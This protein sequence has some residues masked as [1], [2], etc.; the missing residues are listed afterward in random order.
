MLSADARL[1]TGDTLGR[2]RIL[3]RLRAGGMATLYLGKRTGAAGFARP[4][5]IKVIHPHL[6]EDPRFVKM[7]VDEATLSAKIDDP[8]VVHVEELGEAH[9]TY[10]LVMEYVDGI[11]LAQLLRELGRR[12]RALSIDLTTWIA[13]QIAAGLHAA[14]EATNEAGEPLG[15]VHRD[16]SP[17][18]VLLAFKGHVKLIDFG[19]AKSRTQTKDT[20]TGS[21]R[22]K[23]AYMPPEQAWGKSVDRRA[24]VY[25]LGVVIWEMLTM[26]R[27]FDAD[28][29]FLLL[30]RVRAP[31]VKPPSAVVKGI[32]AALD[33]AVMKALSPDPANRPASAEELR[34]LLAHAVPSM[35]AKTA[36]DLNAV[37]HAVVPDLIKGA[38]DRLTELL[39]EQDR[40]SAPP[41]ANDQGRDEE[42]LTTMTIERPEATALFEDDR[43][44]QP[45]APPP[46][47]QPLA[48][49]RSET[50]VPSKS[51]RPVAF[52]L[53]SLAALSV[54][55]LVFAVGVT[56]AG[57][58]STPA[59]AEPTTTAPPPSSVSA[60]ESAPL[61]SATIVEPVASVAPAST[62]AKAVAR[63][64]ASGHAHKPHPPATKSAEKPCGKV[65]PEVHGGT[66]F[67]VPCK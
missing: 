5:A 20:Q 17:H 63:G 32:P 40:P 61:P 45:L 66:P 11:S 38:R 18:N 1:S 55:F 56:L 19:I 30:E 60:V 24:D 7:F 53:V 27:L 51:R 6:A 15:I 22:G 64:T 58:R 44:A 3:S 67:F 46:P 62:P 4:V 37:L 9:G 12:K 25:A 10:F 65:S 14:H 29:D 43:D 36:K 42:A 48:V 33:D 31:S 39:G 2:Y 28:N 21:L 47:V 57:S 16:V 13:A 34:A 54:L 50:T 59:V 35:T 8:H 41:G 26:R 49:G 52:V 23:L